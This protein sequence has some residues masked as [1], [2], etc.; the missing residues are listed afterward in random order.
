MTN[1][2]AN[3]AVTKADKLKKELDKSSQQ[4]KDGV[5]CEKKLRRS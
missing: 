4:Y 1:G 2:H 3:K 5:A